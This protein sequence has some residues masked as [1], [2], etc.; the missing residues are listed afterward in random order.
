MFEILM[1]WKTKID[2]DNIKDTE[3]KPLISEKE[4]ETQIIDVGT[5][6]EYISLYNTEFT[7]AKDLILTYRNMAM[8]YEIGEA[9]DEIENDAVVV[10][11]D[12]S[13]DINTE[14]TEL[15][16]SIQKKIRE[17]FKTILKLLD[18]DAKGHKL[19]RQWF[20]DSRLYQQKVMNK[21]SKLGLEKVIL[22]DPFKI[23]RLKKKE[24]KEIFYQ[25]TYN[26]E[27]TY[28]FP[29]DNITFTTS[30]LVD[31]SNSF[32]ISEL[33]KS[34][35]PLNNLRL[36]EDSA[37]IYYI[38]R[39]PQK[40]AFYIDVGNTSTKKAEQKVKQIM[41][42]FRQ[43]I[44]YDST[45]GKI[46]QQ[47][48]SIPVNEDY[49]FATRGD[50]R[51]TKIETLSGDTALLD[52]EI[53]G[54]FKKKLYKSLAVPYARVDDESSG[55]IIEGVSTETS[56]QELKL[57]KQ[58]SKRRKRFSYMFDDLLK[59]QL[60]SKKIITID[61]WEKIKQDIYY[62]WKNDSYYS[63]LKQQEILAKQINIAL[64]VEPFIGKYFSN[65]YVRKVIFLQSDEDIEQMDKEIAEEKTDERY[66]PATEEPEE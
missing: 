11:N 52:P 12:E 65:D 7:S 16:E 19:F 5:S 45:S 41:Q 38:T 49:Y 32:W 58:T 62:I 31:C 63:M 25:Y 44:S 20:V 24:T 23:S 53:L 37:L 14:R 57:A 40:R 26:D 39:A 43:R 34:I 2:K 64:E 3:Q 1:P 22:L 51:G 6:L 8:N 4:P 10:E 59:T 42:K 35:R 21:N 55:A 9:L 47:K 36:I 54:Y 15:S 66:K 13:I 50:T 60:I 27:E 17:E 46:T 30:G 61:E 28:L 33:H 29:E 56:S 48:R 18:W